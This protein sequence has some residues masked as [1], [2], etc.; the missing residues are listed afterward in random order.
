MSHTFIAH[1]ALGDQLQFR[2][3]EGHE[4]MGRLFHFDVDLLS[5][6]DSIDPKSLLGTDL[7]VEIDL[8]TKA[9]GG[10][11]Y[12]S[13]Q[14]TAFKFAGRDG[15]FYAYRAVLEPWLWLATRR[16]DF[17]IFQN[18]KVPDIV[19]EVL[20][21]YGFVVD[22]KL[23]KSY[24][25]WEY[26]VQY[27]ETDFQFISRL[28]ENEGAYYY[29]AHQM[30]SHHL[31]LADDLGSHS[32][33][34]N[35]PTTIPYYPG[36]RSAHVHDEDFFDSWNALQNIASGKFAAD[37][38]DF[39]KPKALLDTKQTEPAGHA[40]DSWEIY[41]WPGGYTE[42]DDGNNYAQV[43]IEQQKAQRETIHGLGNARNLAPGYL[44]NLDKYPRADQ[45]QRYLITAADYLF[46]ENVQRS[47]GGS[48]DSPTTYR[49][50]VDAVPSSVLPWHSQPLTRKPHTAGPQTAVVVGPP[51]EEIWT[52]QYG[53]VKVQFFWD[54]Y[55]KMDQNSSCWIRVSSSW[56]GSNYGD[57]YIPRI[58]QEVIVDFLNGDPDYPII[59]GR[60]YNAMQMPPWDLPANKTQS[61]IKTKSSKN[62]TPGDGMKNSP[63]T[64]NAIRFEDMAGSEQL[65]LHA[66][67]DQ[68]T[69]VENQEDK[70][71]GADRNK[72]IDGNETNVIHKN[73]T[74]TVDLDETITIHGNRTETVD[75]NEDITIH[76]NRTELVNLNEDVTIGQNQTHTVVLD[77][78]RK[79]GVNESI[80][81]GS[82]RTKSVRLT[83]TD[84]IGILQA[85][86]IGIAR[87]QNVGLAKMTNVGLAYNVNVGVFTMTNT[88]LIRM[89]NVGVNWS[90]TV[91]RNRSADVGHDESLTVG[92][93][94]SVTV[95]ANDST[96]VTHDQAVDVGHD[97]ALKV[98]NNSLTQAKAQLAL[99]A[100]ATLKADG[101]DV[102]VTG[103]SSIRLQCG[104]SIIELTPAMIEIKSPLVKINC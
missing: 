38:Y 63:G 42:V 1:S 39:K 73:R 28:L 93:N 5:D 83:E 18:M 40:Q 25:T 89:D 61:G 29:F 103:A 24:R 13:G 87:L 85:E 54:R 45:N 88:G 95:A 32:P 8:T 41:H 11:R 60:V 101:K 75:K 80:T 82:N 16:S 17:K 26:C 72:T 20:A 19:Q 91:G 27:G 59:T 66:Q 67:K 58:G 90:R 98:G 30:G 47:D 15:D 97:H 46:T 50:G 6:S 53:R 49:L 86:T 22:D 35:G 68:P 92:N 74:E 94:R 14:V 62:G 69:E 4:E 56:A 57:I 79:V 81:I 33:L 70:W 2:H 52:D 64:A 12:L 99:I 37:D 77:R 44:F 100:G 31:V 36:T 3:L 76:Q 71:V 84:T 9:S 55:G 23:C 34:P 43:R 102:I 21:P 65:W 7:T 96:A 104:A 10:T 51:G 48:A 78:T